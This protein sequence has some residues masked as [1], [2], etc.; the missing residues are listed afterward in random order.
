MRPDRYDNLGQL[1]ERELPYLR[2]PHQRCTDPAR[3]AWPVP[4][5][6]GDRQRH[7]RCRPRCPECHDTF[8]ARVPL[9]RPPNRSPGS[10]ARDEALRAAK[11]LDRAPWRRCGGYHRRCRAGTKFHCAKSLGLRLMAR[12]L[13][14]QVAELQVWSAVRS[15]CAALGITVTEAVRH[16]PPGKGEVRPSPDLCNSANSWFQPCARWAPRAGGSTHLPRRSTGRSG[17]QPDCH[18]RNR[19]RGH[20]SLTASTSAVILGKKNL[21]FR[22]QRIAPAKDTI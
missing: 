7:G 8:A 1:P 15:G 12:N 18:L 21:E 13:D 5:A 22:P 14:R 16:V 4:G 9:S 11:Y 10:A 20:P 6:S 3:P 17:R 19:I 2:Q